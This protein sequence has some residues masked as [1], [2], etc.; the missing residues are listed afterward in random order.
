MK[1]FHTLS[2]LVV[3]AAA[4]PTPDTPAA[5]GYPP[6]FSLRN[7]IYGG[8]GCP[9]GSL[10]TAAQKISVSGASLVT[11][12]TAQIG[13]GVPIVNSRA[14]CQLNFDVLYSAGY[15]FSV[16]STVIHGR[17]RLDPGTNGGLTSIFYFSGSVDQVSLDQLTHEFPL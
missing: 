1:L 10:D 2:F 16:S 17:A 6:S 9:Q 4:A 5:A 15:Q 13:P 12:Y 7:T 14:N 3:A 11:S 8:T